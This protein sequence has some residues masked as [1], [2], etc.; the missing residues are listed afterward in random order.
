[1][2]R[3]GNRPGLVGSVL[4]CSI[5]LDQLTKA[6]AKQ[7]LSPL[8]SKV[9]LDGGVRLIYAENTG[10]FSSFGAGLPSELKSILF[11]LLPVLAFLALLLAILIWRGLSTATLVGASLLIG[12]GLSNVLDRLLHQ[13]AVIDF[14]SI[15]VLGYSSSI[16]NLADLAISLG[17]VLLAGAWVSR[18]I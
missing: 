3:F 5:L 10:V 15:N 7:T 18:R 6:V 8:I 14:V 16:F 1:M 17:M 12:G 2:V 4:V 13:G 9:Y 11:T